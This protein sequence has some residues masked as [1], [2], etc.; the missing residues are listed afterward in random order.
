MVELDGGRELFVGAGMQ[1]G[2]EGDVHLVVLPE[3][4]G[5]AF[6]GAR[7]PEMLRVQ[8]VEI[9]ADPWA[10]PAGSQFERLGL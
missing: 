4:H 8:V 10:V 7:L 1:Q 3:H 9:E 6:I 5:T 2:L